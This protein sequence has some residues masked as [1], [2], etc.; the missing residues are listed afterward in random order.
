MRAW[1]GVVVAAGLLLPACSSSDADEPRVLPSA[2]A[3]ASPSASPSPSPAASGPAVARD[4]AKFVEQ[5]Y[6]LV[7]RGFAERDPSGVEAVSLPTCKTCKLYIDSIE[8]LRDKD[9]R[10]EGGGFDIEFA[11][12]PADSAATARVDVKFD[13]RASR[14]LSA[15]GAIVDTYPAMQDVEE[16]VN[17]QMLDGEWRV[18]TI[19]RVVRQ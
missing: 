8:Q 6:A 19:K 12:A 3:A 2:S 7:S 15:D 5:F 9:Q 17:L 13:F 11:V 16:Q 18:V 10:F 4:A 1:V 14:V